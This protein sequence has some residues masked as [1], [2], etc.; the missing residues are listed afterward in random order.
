MKAMRESDKNHGIIRAP[1][2]YRREFHYDSAGNLWD[3]Y[4]PEPDRPDDDDGWRD[5]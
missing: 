4:W 2:F 3:E 1:G 5:E